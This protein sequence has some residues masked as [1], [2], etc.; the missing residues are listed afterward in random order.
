MDLEQ[1][2]LYLGKDWLAVQ[3][4]ILRT[5]DSDIELLNKINGT[6]LANSGKQLRP[7]LALMIARACN[8]GCIN[9]ETVCYA[10]ASELMHNATLIHDDV[11]DSS[12]KRRGKPTLFSMFGPS[13]SVLVGDYWLS[14]A[15]NLILDGESCDVRVIRLYASTLEYLAEGEMLQLQKAENCDMTEEDYLR[16]IYDKTASLFEASCVSAAYSVGASDIFIEGARK[17]AVALGRAFQ[18]KDDILDY[19]G[20]E[21]VGKPL[22]ADILEQKMT[23]PLF[24]AL[25]NNPDRDEYIRGVVRNIAGHPERRDEI[26]SFVRDNGGKEYAEKRL[27]EFVDEAVRALDFMPESRDKDYLVELALFTGNRSK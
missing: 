17:Y 7:I 15:V 8:G 9:R 22:G 3:E 10:A 18:I 26:V 24:G 6:H 11:A 23:M 27:A 21:T 4:C 16:V 1:I 2:R 14:K 5:L 12:A 25:L 19:F 20:T 13:V